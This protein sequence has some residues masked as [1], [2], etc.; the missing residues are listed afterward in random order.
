MARTPKRISQT[1]FPTT[2]VG[3][4]GGRP[5]RQGLSWQKGG[6]ACAGAALAASCGTAVLG[7]TAAVRS[8]AVAGAVRSCGADVTLCVWEGCCCRCGRRP[9][10]G[11][12]CRDARLGWAAVAAVLWD[13]RHGRCAS[14]E[15]PVGA[16]ASSPT[17]P[18]PEPRPPRRSRFMTMSTLMWLLKVSS[19]RECT[20]P[21]TVHSSCSTILAAM[22]A[23]C[24]SRPRRRSRRAAA[25]GRPTRRRGPARVGLSSA[26]WNVFVS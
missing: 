4:R 7:S 20:V 18:S 23:A 8:G 5:L 26:I 9:A 11:G 12:G 25:V 1:A 24:R 17:P 6:P 15:A 22:C 13:R 10:G 19:R 2:V 16:P 21:G 3:T 14:S